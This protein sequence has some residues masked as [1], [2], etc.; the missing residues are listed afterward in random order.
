MYVEYYETILE[1]KLLSRN[2]ILVAD[3]TLFRGLVV[4]KD[5]QNKTSQRIHQFN[6]HV[7]KDHRTQKV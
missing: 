6:E 3:N 1:R 4:Q 2:G 5:V 7:A